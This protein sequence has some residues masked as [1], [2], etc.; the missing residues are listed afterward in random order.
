MCQGQYNWRG[1][2]NQ[3]I[4]GEKEFLFRKRGPSGIKSTRKRRGGRKFVVVVN[5][6]SLL[7]RQKAR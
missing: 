6:G 7:G 1:I 5:E 3:G 4:F 2:E